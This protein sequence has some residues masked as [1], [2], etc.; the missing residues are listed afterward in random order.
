MYKWKKDKQY[1]VQM[2]KIRNIY[3]ASQ[4]TTHE[5]ID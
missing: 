4:N 5:S 3:N 2:E 1:N